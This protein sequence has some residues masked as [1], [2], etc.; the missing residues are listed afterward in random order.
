MSAT[1]SRPR[2]NA[3]T[4]LASVVLVALA[5]LAYDS[6]RD[7]FGAYRSGRLEGPRGAYVVR[8]CDPSGCTG[9]FTPDRGAPVSG[10][11]LDA[12]GNFRQGEKGRVVLA[13]GRAVPLRPWGYQAA[14]GTG[15]TLAVAALAIFLLRGRRAEERT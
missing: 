3:T 4:L 9:D 8:H 5:V 15:A 2:R 10:V 13:D 6:G 12:G 7:A 14:V 1:A 11:P